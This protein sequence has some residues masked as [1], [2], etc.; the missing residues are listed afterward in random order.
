MSDETKPKYGAGHLE[1]MINLGLNELRGAVYPES[2]V[3]QPPEYGV[4]GRPTPG[5]IADGRRESGREMEGEDQPSVLAER[6]ADIQSRARGEDRQPSREM[7][8]E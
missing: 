3:A 1:A 2:N 4:F 6:E 5:E 7:E 8:R